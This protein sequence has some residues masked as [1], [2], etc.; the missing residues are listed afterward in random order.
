MEAVEGTWDEIDY[1]VCTFQR[2]TQ[3]IRYNPKPI[4]T[5]PFAL[6]LG[7]GCEIAMVGARAQDAAETYMVLVGRGVGDIPGG[8]GATEMR[9][10]DGGGGTRGLR[11][12]GG[13]S[14]LETA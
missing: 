9:R 6:T 11:E 12:C 7:G 14:V 5:A 8:G 2:A 1:M 4:V 13:D 10:R 3:A